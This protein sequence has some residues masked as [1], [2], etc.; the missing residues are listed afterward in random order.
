M[1]IDELGFFGRLVQAEVT[2]VALVAQE[3]DSVLTRLTQ[4][5]KRVFR[6]VEE[7]DQ[8]RAGTVDVRAESL[9]ALRGENAVISARVLA[10]VD[11]EQIRPRLIPRERKAIRCWQR[12]PRVG[13]AS[14]SPTCASP[15]LRRLRRPSPSLI[16]TSASSRPTPVRAQRAPHLHAGAQHGHPA[17][18]DQ[19]RQRRR[20]DGR[21]SGTVMGPARTVTAAFTVLVGGMPLA[22]LTSI[23]VQNSTNAPG[24]KVV[25]SVTN[26]LVLAP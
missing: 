7:I 9:L 6:F 15:R 8:T 13:C 17:D 5:A 23:T 3:V 21:R 12:P 4:R 14:R 26:V 24:A 2:R 18:D 16:R 22:R 20:G 25:P 11:G 19:R 10:K 1:A